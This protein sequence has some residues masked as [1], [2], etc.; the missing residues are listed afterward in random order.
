MNSKL[1]AGIV[2]IL[3]VSAGSAWAGYEGGATTYY[4]YFSALALEA[5]VERL[6]LPRR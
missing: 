3:T 1:C 4:G 6:T 5:E 2:T